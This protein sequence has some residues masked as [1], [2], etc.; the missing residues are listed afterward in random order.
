MMKQNLNQGRSVGADQ[1]IEN[2]S[3]FS[4]NCCS[5][6]EFSISEN[7][8]VASPVALSQAVRVHLQNSR[9]GTVK[10]KSRSDLTSRSNKKPWR[11][12]GTGRARAGSPRSP[13]WRGGGVCFGPQ[14]RV[15]KLFTNKKMNNFMAAS[16]FFDL[17]EEK[18]VFVANIDFEIYSTN[19]AN[20]F[21]K[22]YNLEHSKVVIIYDNVDHYVYYSFANIKGVSLVSLDSI[23]VYDLVGA[24]NVIFLKKNENEFKRVVNQWLSQNI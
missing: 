6:D 21:L 3:E 20:F 1:K 23:S 18:K 5:L 2:F 11:Q 16:L 9:Q 7:F 17:L 10:V 19:Q 13:L 22:K 4:L 15:R 24:S 12:K 8:C 14:P